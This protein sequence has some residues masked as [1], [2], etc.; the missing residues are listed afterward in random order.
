VGT[1]IL[2]GLIVAIWLAMT[3][4]G[5]SEDPYVLLAFGAKYNPLIA[6]GQYWRLLTATF[7][8]IGILHLLFNGYSLYILGSMVESR[9]G[10]SRFV[11]LYLLAGVAGSTASFLG[12]KAL[13]AGAS[14]A[15]FGLMGAVIVYFA[16]YR[17]N[18][19]S[20]G[21]QLSSILMV[22][23]F[24]LVWGL[25]SQQIDNLGH[26]GGLIAGLLLGLAFCPR[27]RPEGA[28]ELGRPRRADRYSRPLAVFAAL[29]LSVAIAA[30][31]MLGV[32]I[33]S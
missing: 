31:V 17:H 5:G 30:L 4:L 32:H 25:S 8:H 22:A 16:R 18:L 24:N 19:P 9:F 33:Q 27:Y 2:L 11:I 23:G 29:A 15:I 7:L 10:H 20:G 28:P 21:R 6:A 14:G 12:N 3:A 13:S 1:Y 26:V